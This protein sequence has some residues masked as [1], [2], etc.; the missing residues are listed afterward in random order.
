MNSISML[1]IL[2]QIS[3]LVFFAAGISLA[4][5]GD[6]TIGEEAEAV[7]GVV[8]TNA[9]W[10]DECVEISNFGESAQ[11]L[12]GWTLKDEQDHTYDFPEGFTLAPGEVVMVHTGV[13]DDTDTDLY[14]NMGSPIWNNAGDVATLMDGEGNVVSQYPEPEEDL[15]DE[16]DAEPTE[17]DE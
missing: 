4:E 3:A 13:G 17:G 8:I 16:V 11:D 7:Y 2:V 14:C 10:V 5:D 1:R 12:T 6:A 15:N 9:S